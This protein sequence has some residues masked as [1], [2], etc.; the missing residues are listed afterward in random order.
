LISPGILRI[1]RVTSAVILGSDPDSARLALA[2]AT[3][4]TAESGYD[5]NITAQHE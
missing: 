4:V 3:V 1:N 2:W 5:P